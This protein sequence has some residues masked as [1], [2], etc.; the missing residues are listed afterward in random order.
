MP[1]SSPCLFQVWKSEKSLLFSKDL[2][3]PSS[4]LLSHRLCGTRCRT[5]SANMSNYHVQVVC[6]DFLESIMTLTALQTRA[7]AHSLRVHVCTVLMCILLYTSTMHGRTL[8]RPRLVNLRGKRSELR[9]KTHQGTV[10]IRF[11]AIHYNNCF[12]RMYI[13][14]Y[15]GI[16]VR[17]C[18]VFSSRPS[19][20]IEALTL[21]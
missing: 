9:R 15:A 10:Q 16:S 5:C 20:P 21:L 1:E 11:M 13:N 3:L 14:E 8:L 2:P 17:N 4:S 6:T 12:Q 19:L 7:I 18:Q